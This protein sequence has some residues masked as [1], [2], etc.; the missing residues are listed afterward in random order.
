MKCPGVFSRQAD[1]GS[2]ELKLC[3][4]LF[5][6][7]REQWVGGSG[8]PSRYVLLEACTNIV[9]RAFGICLSA[10]R[11]AP[12]RRGGGSCDVDCLLLTGVRNRGRRRKYVEGVFY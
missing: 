6:L 11:A 9:R 12:E 5:A 2:K 10:N 4:V 8:A 3:L 1:V 7:I